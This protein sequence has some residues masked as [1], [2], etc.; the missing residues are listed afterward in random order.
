VGNCFFGCGV[1]SP[2][3]Q[4]TK[5][6][7]LNTTSDALELNVEFEISNTNDSPIQLKMYTYAVTVNGDTVYKGKCSAEL[8]VPRW[9]TAT[10]S[11]PVVISKTEILDPSN[12]NWSLMGSLEYVSP[13]AFAEALR[14]SGFLETSTK[15]NAQGV[16]SFAN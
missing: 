10:S 2:L 12:I 15:V 4:F 5:S 7:I 9:S 14:T 16:C 13:N 6:S 1:A 11:V 8:T 3:A